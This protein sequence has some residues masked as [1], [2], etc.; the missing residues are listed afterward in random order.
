MLVVAAT[1]VSC[2]RGNNTSKLTELQ[3]I[4]S[5]TL[6]VVVLSPRDGLSHGKDAFIIEFRSAAGGDIVDVGNVRGSANMP[7]P[8]TPMFGSLDI[9][10]TDVPGRYAANGEFPMAGTWRVTLEWDGPAGRG[11]VAFPGTV[12]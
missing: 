1:A 7:M 6:D 3:R 9:Q 5:G 10:R 2:G 8:G 11:S 12:H 4:R